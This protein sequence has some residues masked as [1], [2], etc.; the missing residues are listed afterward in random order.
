MQIFAHRGS[1]GTRPE[2]TL[3]AFA[4]A[5]RIGTDGIELDVQLT[6]D[7]QLIVMHDETVDRTTDGK[8]AIIDKTLA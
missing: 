3:P 2:N 4:E 1:S 6:K 5:V 7:Q 8:G